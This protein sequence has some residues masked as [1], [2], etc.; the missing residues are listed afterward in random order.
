MR[1]PVQAWA[2]WRSR[3]KWSWTLS[4]LHVRDVQHCLATIKLRSSAENSAP[5]GISAKISAEQEQEQEK[6]QEAE[7]EHEPEYEHEHEHEHEQE[8]EQE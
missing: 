2:S 6:D 5:S 4:S 8:T 1:R 3:R 7:H